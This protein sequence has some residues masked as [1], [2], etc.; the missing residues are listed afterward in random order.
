MPGF[1][2]RQRYLNGDE[3][4]ILVGPHAG[5]SGQ[6]VAIHFGDSESLARYVVAATESSEERLGIFEPAHLR[7]LR[8]GALARGLLRPSSSGITSLDHLLAGIEAIIPPEWDFELSRIG[9]NEG[10]FRY[11]AYAGDPRDGASDLVLYGPSR[12]QAVRQLRDA[13]ER[14]FGPSS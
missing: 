14:R 1:L 13:L 4:M 2:S 9:T 7:G 11:R 5:E 6:V 12:W 8:E 10:D 3:V